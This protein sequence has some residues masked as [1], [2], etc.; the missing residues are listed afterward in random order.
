M[1]LIYL[2][3]PWVPLFRGVENCIY[4]WK[5]HFFYLIWIIYFSLKNAQ[6]KGSFTS[7]ASHNWSRQESSSKGSLEIL[8]A[9]DRQD[10]A[11]GARVPPAAEAVFRWAFPEHSSIRLVS[12]N[13]DSDKSVFINVGRFSA[14]EPASA[15]A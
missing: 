8:R 9:A 12:L 4:K 15:L 3:F 10:K 13:E 6:H 2:F 14:L 11:P 1:K 7:S 5:S